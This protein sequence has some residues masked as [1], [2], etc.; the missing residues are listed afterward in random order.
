MLLP[1]SVAGL[2]LSCFLLPAANI[3]FSQGFPNK[4]IRIVTSSAGGGGDIAARL[5]GQRLSA[6]WGQQVIVDNRG[7]VLPGQIVA[8]A[9]PDGYNL[10]L[11]SG[12]LWIGPLL[13]KTPYDAVRDFSPITITDRTP[14]I[15][16]VHPSVAAGSVKEL[17]AL[18]KAKPGGLSYGSGTPGAV[19]HVAGELFKSMAGVNLLHVPYKNAPPAIIDLVGGQTQ[20]MFATSSSV[21]SHVK[22]GKLRGLAV[23]TAA[24]SEL[25]PGLPTVAASGLPG[26][27]AASINAVFGPARMS[28]KLV[29]QINREIVRVLSQS[30]LKEK[31]FS[32][33]VETVGSS[34]AQL[35]ALVKSEMVTLGKIFKDLNI[36]LD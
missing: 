36:R 32:M 26:Y 11:F 14:C 2:F 35:A 3:V 23:T 15:I 17:I 22:S 28:A 6:I 9:S 21:S 24:P 10:L 5:I 7:G 30:E 29:D 4:P 18:A 13:Q 8:A 33:G 19:T 1:R 16:V 31:L 20:V 27:E 34:P 12:A 25:V